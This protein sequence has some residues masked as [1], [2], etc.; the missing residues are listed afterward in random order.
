PS[1]TNE[2]IMADGTRAALSD[3]SNDPGMQ[4]FWSLPYT[5]S[6]TEPFGTP[7]RLFAAPVAD[8]P[9]RNYA[10]DAAARHFVF[11]QHLAAPSPREIRL[12]QRW[13]AVLSARSSSIPSAS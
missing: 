2:L 12:I 10:V 5:P 11:K 6:S 13:H 9:G 4:A 8:F 7:K 1:G 3:I